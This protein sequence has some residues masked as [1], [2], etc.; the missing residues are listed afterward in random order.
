MSPG[1][2]GEASGLIEDRVAEQRSRTSGRD[3]GANVVQH[4][5]AEADRFDADR[6]WKRLGPSARVNLDGIVEPSPC[7]DNQQQ[8]SVNV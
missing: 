7:R 3:L 2:D 8:T 4:V 5:S 1:I 6:F